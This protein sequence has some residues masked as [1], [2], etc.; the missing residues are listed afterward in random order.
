MWKSAHIF[1]NVLLLWV[2]I[3]I[4]ENKTF[5]DIFCRNLI[6][7]HVDGDSWEH[8][9]TPTSPLGLQY[10]T[11]YYHVITSWYALA[12]AS[13]YTI[14][15]GLCHCMSPT[16]HHSY[17]VSKSELLPGEDGVLHTII[18]VLRVAMLR[19]YTWIQFIVLNTIMKIYTSFT[20]IRREDDFKVL[21]VNI[22]GRL[23]NVC[24]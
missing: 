2:A 21:P 1:I 4:F 23:K 5:V 24:I 9:T 16:A 20:Q 17:I 7:T 22:L 13:G 10:I 12:F 19:L 18:S 14:M 8:V 6:L 11:V 15:Y 3:H